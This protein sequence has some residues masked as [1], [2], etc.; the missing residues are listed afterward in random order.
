MYDKVTDGLFKYEVLSRVF[1]GGGSS[2]GTG[3]TCLTSGKRRQTIFPEK[4]G[5]WS[6]TVNCT[7]R[8]RSSP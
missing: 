4:V 7:G 2:E 6:S 3:G 8:R 5:V 1:N